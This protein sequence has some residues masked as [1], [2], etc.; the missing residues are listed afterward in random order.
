[1]RNSLRAA[2]VLVATTIS[3]STLTA[4]APSP[5]TDSLTVWADSLE[6]KAL[7]KV[8]TDFE[9]A[10]H[11]KINLVA[12]ED[13]S[14]AFTEAAK[15]GNAPDIFLGSDSSTDSFVSE[16]LILP[17][18]L[19]KNKDAFRP[20]A[21][22]AFSSNGSL[23]GLPYSIEN[24]ALVCNATKV[25]SAPTWQQAVSAGV[26]INFDRGEG[27]NLDLYAIQTS[28][29]SKI[30]KQDANGGYLPDLALADGGSD[31][32]NWLATDGAKI[33]NVNSTRESASK[34]LLEGTSGCWITGSAS[35]NAS[36]LK[37][38]DYSVY[39]IPSVGGQPA[40]QFLTSRGFFV[41]STTKDPYYAQKFLTDFVAT[42]DVQAELFKDTG[43]VPAHLATLD[44][45][46]GDKEIAGFSAAGVNAEPY[47]SIPKM[48][49][50]VKYLGAAEMTILNGLGNPDDIWAKMI[51]NIEAD[52]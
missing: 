4:C 8:A 48:K 24:D 1:M 45:A 3:L 25:P 11:I 21:I 30:F 20:N 13:S 28:F 49:S 51:A 26:Q 37:G 6:L 16:K 2:A 41:S 27:V 42:A 14:A 22:R 46:S 35:L 47:P 23:Y 9:N 18:D 10:N 29:G 31:F 40:V 50:V 33:F 43:R 19:G 12:K 7:A 36:D 44:G 34:A 52:K 5:K 17:L 39:P 38:S 15:A 32:A